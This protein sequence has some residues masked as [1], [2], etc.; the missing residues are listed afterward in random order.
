MLGGELP[1]LDLHYELYGD[2]GLPAEKTIVVMPSFSHGPHATSSLVD[3][4]PGWWEEM[5]G[6]AKW[7]D[8][9]LYK[10]F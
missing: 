3:P 6:P 5:I 7:I 8:T 2:A 1:K 4:T 10:V 9:N